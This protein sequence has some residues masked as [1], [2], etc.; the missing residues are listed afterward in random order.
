M[1]KGMSLL[2]LIPV[3]A[4]ADW[5]SEVANS[6]PPECFEIIKQNLTAFKEAADSARVDISSLESRY[7]RGALHAKGILVEKSD[8]AALLWFRKAAEQGHSEAQYCLGLAHLEG[9]GCKADPVEAIACFQKAAGGESIEARYRLGLAYLDGSGGLKIDQA[10]AVKWLRK[11]ANLGHEEA[12]KRFKIEAEKLH[13]PKIEADRNLAEQGDVEG[14]YRL[15]QLLSESNTGIQDYVEAFRWCQKASDKGNA[16]AQSLLAAMYKNGWGV[17]AD[18]QVSLKWLRKAVEQEDPRGMRNYAVSYL[19]YGGEGVSKDVPE[20]LRLL[21]KAASKGDLRA[22][23]TLAYGYVHGEWGLPKSDQMA[24]EW[25]S[26]PLEKEDASA[27]WLVAEICYR[28]K[29]PEA[30]IWYFKAAENGDSE[31][32]LMLGDLYAHKGVEPIVYQSYRKA[33]HFYRTAATK[34]NRNAQSR[35]GA[36]LLAQ[37][38]PEAD[39]EAIAWLCKAATQGDA[40]AKSLLVQLMEQGRIES[41]DDIKFVK[42]LSAGSKKESPGK[43]KPDMAILESLLNDLKQAVLGGN[44][45]DLT[46]WQGIDGNYLLYRRSDGEHLEALIKVVEMATQNFSRQTLRDKADAILRLLRGH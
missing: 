20:G 6:E 36:W 37:Q 29:S 8:E 40:N 44:E 13:R 15:A 39:R 11:A 41:D 24:L 34:G 12:G 26:E 18:E 9:K 14:Q 33:M 31:S 28:E 19:L 2:M 45:V 30:V 5:Q 7:I 16:A 46:L 22:K 21:R 1:R 3:I 27:L 38:R 32:L 17:I 43:Y 10:A 42:S 35:L 25:I 4:H 23:F